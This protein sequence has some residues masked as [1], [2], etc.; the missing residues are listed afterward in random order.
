MC[1]DSCERRGSKALGEE[2]QQLSKGLTPSRGVPHG[3]DYHLLFAGTAR[4]FTP[5]LQAQK[6]FLKASSP[7]EPPGS[8]SL[9]QLME[10]PPTTPT[11]FSYHRAAWGRQI[12]MKEHP[13]QGFTGKGRR[14]WVSAA[15]YWRH[16][17][18]PLW[19]CRDK[20]AKCA[21]CAL[22]RLP[23]EGPR[24]L[25]NQTNEFRHRTTLVKPMALYAWKQR[26]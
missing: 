1:R 9:P 14:S 10:D 5:C 6:S 26:P 17:F 7:R 13:L 2:Q 4:S 3:S 20:Q 22:Y 16:S 23:P 15:G 19:T 21:L 18:L 8:K 24:A 11:G 12:K 25:Q